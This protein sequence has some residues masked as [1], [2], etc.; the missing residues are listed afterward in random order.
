MQTEIFYSVQLAVR[1]L[2]ACQ[3]LG[4]GAQPRRRAHIHT[5]EPMLN[6]HGTAQEG[7]V[8]TACTGGTGPAEGPRGLGWGTS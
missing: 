1:L 5:G 3:L 4:R 8:G 7:A 6:E 2:S